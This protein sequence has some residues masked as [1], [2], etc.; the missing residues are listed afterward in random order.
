MFA[1]SGGNRRA[2]HG[3][4]VIAGKTSLVGR[5]DTQVWASHVRRRRTDERRICLACGN[6]VSHH[7]VGADVGVRGRRPRTVSA[8]GMSGP[9]LRD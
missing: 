6:I 8:V 2:P 4:S 5:G 9:R 1:H 7:Q 3:L